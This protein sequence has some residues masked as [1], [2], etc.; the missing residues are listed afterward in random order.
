MISDDR[1]DPFVTRDRDPHIKAFAGHADELLGGDVRRDQRGADGPPGE[2]PF[3][4]EEVGGGSFGALLAL[5]NP[6]PVRGDQNEVGE[7][8]DVVDGLHDGA[9]DEG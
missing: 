8:D 5:V 7:E 6:N 3:G 1:R 9:G 4:K 2:R